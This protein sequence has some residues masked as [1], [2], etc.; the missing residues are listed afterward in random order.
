MTINSTLVVLFRLA[1]GKTFEHQASDISYWDLQLWGNGTLAE[2]IG[3]HGQGIPR[4]SEGMVR[5]Y[6]LICY[7]IPHKKNIVIR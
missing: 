6:G 5:V 3:R 7:H 2:N 4:R 1:C